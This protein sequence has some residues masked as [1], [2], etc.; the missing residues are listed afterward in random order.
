MSTLERKC[1]SQYNQL[2]ILTS[3][4]YHLFIFGASS[5]TEFIMP[6]T[7][8]LHSWADQEGILCPMSYT[9]NY[10]KCVLYQQSI[11]YTLKKNE[12]NHTVVLYSNCLYHL[13]AYDCLLIVTYN[14]SRN[15]ELSHFCLLRQRGRREGKNNMRSKQEE[16]MNII[17]IRRII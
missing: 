12:Q 6:N 15:V 9:N 10:G 16:F 11:Y 2:I 5:T 1:T 8:P 7:W 17:E 3:F 14:A 4:S 13:M